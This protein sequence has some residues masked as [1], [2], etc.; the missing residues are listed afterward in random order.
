VS[1]RSNYSVVD[2]TDNEK[3]KAKLIF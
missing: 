2:Q 3:D 1:Y